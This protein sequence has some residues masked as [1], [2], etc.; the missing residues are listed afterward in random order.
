MRPSRLLL[1]GLPALCLCS[2]ARAVDAQANRPQVPAA[3][4]GVYAKTPEALRP[5][6]QFDEPY[7]TFFLTEL[8]YPGY[9]RHIPP[10]EH[11]ST[12][13]IGFIGP[14]VGSV[15]ESVGGPGDV[16]LRVNERQ[17]RWD[18]Y[19]ASYLAPI[20]IKMLQGARLAVAQT[21]SGEASWGGN[22]P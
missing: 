4:S 1:A 22:C 16:T 5:Y 7:K 18:G 13:K 8:E 3:D 10:P 21:L 9:G 14:I 6:S 19:A 15:S 2:L 20:G 17:A 11:V 12:V